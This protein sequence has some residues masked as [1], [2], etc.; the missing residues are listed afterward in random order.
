MVQ[1]NCPSKKSSGGQQEEGHVVVNHLQQE[2]HQSY[3]K[4]HYQNA[5]IQGGQIK[6]RKDKIYVSFKYTTIV[7]QS[8]TVPG[9]QF[10][11]S[12]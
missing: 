8:T 12:T 9:S 5:S 2:H 11:G 10:I 3:L 1:P 4:H 7:E 6:C